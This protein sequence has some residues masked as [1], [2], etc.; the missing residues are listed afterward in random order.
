MSGKKTVFIEQRLR[1]N[2][3]IVTLLFPCS[4]KKTE[5][6]LHS[7]ELCWFYLIL[8]IS[9]LLIGEIQLYYSLLL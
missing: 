5:S 3:S 4:F 9:V 8:S 6:D 1:L 2:K 7:V